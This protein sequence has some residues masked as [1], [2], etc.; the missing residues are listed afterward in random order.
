MALATSIVVPQ[1]MTITTALAIS[2]VIATIALS[3][4]LAVWL[5]CR[6]TPARRRDVI[7]LARAVIR[8]G[9]RP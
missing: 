7:R 6:L 9:R 1:E 3:T 8:G 4:I 2:I 5:F